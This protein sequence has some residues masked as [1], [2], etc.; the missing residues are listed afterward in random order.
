MSEAGVLAGVRVVE[1]AG[2]FMVP[3]CASILASSGADVIKIEPAGLAD[4]AGTTASRSTANRPRSPS[5][6]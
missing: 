2:W 4:P 5:S 3:G 6:W 1:L